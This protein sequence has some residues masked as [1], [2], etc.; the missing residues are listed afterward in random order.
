MNEFQPRRETLFWIGPIRYRFLPHPL[1][2][3]E[4]EVYMLEGGQALIYP[5]Q[6][7]DSGNL[8]ALKVS[9]PLYRGEQL[10]RVAAALIHYANL[11]GLSLGR[12]LCLTKATHPELIAAYPSLEYALLMPWI[13]GR[14]WAGLMLDQQASQNYTPQQAHLL[15]LTTAQVLASLEAHQLAHTDIA[16]SNIMLA[17]PAKVEL[18]DIEGLWMPGL[19]RPKWSNQGSPGYQHRRLGRKGQWQ[20][21][22]DRFAGAILLAEMLTWCYPQIRAL[23]PPGSETLFQSD[24]LQKEHSPKWQ[25]V[26]QAL[27]SACAPALELFDQ[28]WQSRKLKQ[29]P[30]LSAWAKRLVLPQVQPTKVGTQDNQKNW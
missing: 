1:F 23:V 29:C 2:P 7:V 11:P 9:K 19:K 21:E 18:L 17:A 10:A 8:Y 26:R 25:S 24:E 4:D 28:A 27:W 6:E 12:R 5:L 13:Q 16:G 14:T 30:P 20:P 22:G 15:A 3:Q